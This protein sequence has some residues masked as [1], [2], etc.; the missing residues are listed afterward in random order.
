MKKLLG[1]DP[2]P[3]P[4]KIKVKVKNGDKDDVFKVE[5]TITGWNIFAAAFVKFWSYTANA[6]IICYVCPVVFNKF[7]MPMTASNSI[8]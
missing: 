6:I 2:H 5:N 4:T 7:A 3:K 1:L 8:G